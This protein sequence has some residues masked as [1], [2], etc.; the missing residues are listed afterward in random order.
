[1]NVF[2]STKY[3]KLCV[4]HSCI[5]PIPNGLFYEKNGTQTDAGNLKKNSVSNHLKEVIKEPGFLCKVHSPDRYSFKLTYVYCKCSCCMNYAS[6]IKA[7][8]FL[9]TKGNA[10]F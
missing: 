1:M 9:V 8:M 5:P 6:A 7:A 4:E 10:A 2:S 3:F